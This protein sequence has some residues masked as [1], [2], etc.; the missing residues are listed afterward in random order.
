MKVKVWWNDRWQDG[1]VNVNVVG[2]K[3][4]V[5]VAVQHQAVSIPFE[6]EQADELIKQLEQSRLAIQLGALAEKR[7]KLTNLRKVPYRTPECCAVCRIHEHKVCPPIE[8]MFASACD[9]FKPLYEWPD[10]S[11]RSEP[12]PEHPDAAD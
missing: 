12:P 6:G 10:G 1:Q 8:D 4:T 2:D 5:L 9:L 7:K 3:I 11:R